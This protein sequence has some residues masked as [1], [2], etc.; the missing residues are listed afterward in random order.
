MVRWN[1]ALSVGSASGI[2]G[3]GLALACALV[4]GTGQTRA[5]AG[6]AHAEAPT[7]GSK[8]FPPAAADSEAIVGR[9]KMRSETIDLTRSSVAI[10]GRAYHVGQGVAQEMADIDVQARS[11][12]RGEN[13]SDVVPRRGRGEAQ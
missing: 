1:K 4:M 5:G 6:V 3:V 12:K 13:R 10:G 9:V 7:P 8:V 2:M 11:A